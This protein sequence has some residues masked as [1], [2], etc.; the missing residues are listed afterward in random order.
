MKAI[1]L[2]II[3]GL[4]A[5]YGSYFYIGTTSWAIP[6]TVSVIR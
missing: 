2:G 6:P 4:L 5:A 1:L 3:L